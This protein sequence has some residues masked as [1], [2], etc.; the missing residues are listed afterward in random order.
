MKLII[1]HFYTR[2][3]DIHISRVRRVFRRLTSSLYHM[4]SLVFLHKC[5]CYSLLKFNTIINVSVDILVHIKHSADF[6]TWYD[7]NLVSNT[8]RWLDD[9]I[10]DGWRDLISS[11]D[12][13]KLK[14]QCWLYSLIWCQPGFEYFSLIRWLYWKWLTRPDEFPRHLK[15][16]RLFYALLH[17]GNL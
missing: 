7:V 16:K 10:E 12:T 4:H 14:A 6:I 15:A 1:T 11:R 9:F 5:M 3:R 17:L 8:F 2:G 13:W